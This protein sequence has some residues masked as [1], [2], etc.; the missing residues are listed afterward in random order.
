MIFLAHLPIFL[1]AR[2]WQLSVRPRPRACGGS[3]IHANFAF[4]AKRIKRLIVY[5]SASTLSDSRSSI[6]KTI[7]NV[8]SS[9][10]VTLRAREVLAMLRHWFAARQAPGITCC[11]QCSAL[12]LEFSWLSV[13]HPALMQSQ[14]LPKLFVGTFLKQTEKSVKINQ[15]Y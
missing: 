2:N 6:S 11:L 10:K 4:D 15:T 3:L 7:R 8:Y 14:S 13:P 1:L 5:G 9:R 12:C